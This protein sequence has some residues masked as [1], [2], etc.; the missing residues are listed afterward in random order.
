MNTLVGVK[1][2][3]SLDLSDLLESV[4][5]CYMTNLVV[6]R[7]CIR[8]GC[9]HKP[10]CKV[11]LLRGMVFQS[12]RLWEDQKIFSRNTV[13]PVY[14][15]HYTFFKSAFVLSFCLSFLFN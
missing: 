11:V 14:A 8:V 13:K 15:R 4:T 2:M 12:Q 9:L 1:N 6:R 5:R 10:G 7:T 3:R